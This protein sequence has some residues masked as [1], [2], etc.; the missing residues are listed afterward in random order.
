[1]RN[2]IAI[3]VIAVFA[4]VGCV[5][6]PKQA[7]F[8]SLYSVE[9]LTTGAYDGY[10]DSVLNGQSTTNGVPRV[11]SAYNKFQSSFVI[12][13]DAVQFNTNA[14]A[15]TSLVIESGD[16]INLINQFKNK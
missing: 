11:S 8:N 13:L 5:T 9:K 16:V 4:V 3:L 14:L 1:M 2:Q 12:A 7:A 15:P 6:T 10:I